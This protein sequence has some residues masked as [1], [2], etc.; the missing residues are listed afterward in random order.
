MTIATLER[1]LAAVTADEASDA[2][3]IDLQFSTADEMHEGLDNAV[4]TL[5][6]PAK[7]AACGI[8]VT[9][10]RPGRFTVALDESVPFG[11]T[12]E[13]IAA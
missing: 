9:R 12:Y 5:I 1:P 11:E 6:E 7:D 13:S 3:S 4:A 2:R 8:L 10:L